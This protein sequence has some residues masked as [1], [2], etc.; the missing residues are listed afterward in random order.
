M[1]KSLVL[2]GTVGVLGI[3]GLMSRPAHAQRVVDVTPG[4]NAEEVS[5]D[6]L[7]SGVFDTDSGDIDVDSVQVYVDG[8]EVTSSSS[9]T[10]NF[11]SYRPTQPLS[12]GQHQIQVEYINTQGQRRVASWTFTV[13]NPQP[14]LTINS[15][16]HNATE[17]LA[18]DATLLT[19]INGTPGAQAAVLLIEDGTVVREVQADEVSSGV[20]VASYSL[21]SSNV[22]T[23]TIAVGQLQRGD[24]KIFAAATQPVIITASTSTSEVTDVEVGEAATPTPEV[25]DVAVADV[26]PLQ[27]EFTSHSNGD[28]IATSGFTLVGRTQPNATVEITVD[29]TTSVAGGFLSLGSDNLVDTTVN[30]DINGEFSI[31]VPAPLVLTDD[32]RY[33][34]EAS[35][36]LGD[37]ISSMTRLT[38]EQE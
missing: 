15:V 27:P 32:T 13:E 3:A 33:E 1:K 2:L 21:N 38:L 10:R 37:E 12:P 28:A 31:R 34:I 30:A 11:F 4:V 7:I 29:S 5:A 23:E 25:S 24:Q 17:P 9:I 14:A 36:Q 18:Q 26:I 16:T 19:T 20:Y 8:Q 35:A 6:A 22:S